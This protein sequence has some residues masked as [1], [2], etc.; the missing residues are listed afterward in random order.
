MGDSFRYQDGGQLN[1]YIA[2]NVR[3]P[4]E[5]GQHSGEQHGEPELSSSRRLLHDPESVNEPL[6]T[7]NGTVDVVEEE[8]KRHTTPQCQVVDASL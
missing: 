3:L 8:G 1:A 6:L 7:V 2:I 4:W 5:Q